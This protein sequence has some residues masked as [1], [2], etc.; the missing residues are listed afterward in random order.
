MAKYS[1]YRLKGKCKMLR[2]NTR[3][4]AAIE[5]CNRFEKPWPEFATLPPFLTI[6]LTVVF[7]SLWL[8]LLSNDRKEIRPLFC[9]LQVQLAEADHVPIVLLPRICVDFLAPQVREDP[10]AIGS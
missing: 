1:S 6:I 10:L 5:S 7:I 4:E 3:D 9:F 8:H 2:M